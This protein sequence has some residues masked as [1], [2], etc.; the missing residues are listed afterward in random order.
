MDETVLFEIVTPAKLMLS[1]EVHLVVVPG[2]GGNIGILPRHA[3]LLASLRPG[4]IDIHDEKMKVIEKIFVEQGF[5]DI[6]PERCTVL[7]EEAMAVRDISRDEAETRLKRAHDALM[8]AETLGIRL[9]AER[10]V[11]AAEAM[12]EAVDAYEKG[13][14][15]QS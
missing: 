6:T 3:P 15:R 11:Q 5:V 12:V 4:T 1:Q 14:A 13:M 10:D 7:A 2:E 8:V 9:V